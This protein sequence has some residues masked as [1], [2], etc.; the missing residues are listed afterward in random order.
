MLLCRTTRPL[1]KGET[2]RGFPVATALAAC[3][4]QGLDGAAMKAAVVKRWR[5]RSVPNAARAASR[6]RGFAFGA[7]SNCHGVAM[8]GGL[9]FTLQGA[10]R[11][12][13]P[14]QWWAHNLPPPSAGQRLFR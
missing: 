4:P 2:A 7:L 12:V 14:L 3:E 1:P 8:A 10:R 13:K 11:R 6:W 5:K 9:L